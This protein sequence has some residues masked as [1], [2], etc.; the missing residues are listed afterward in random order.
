MHNRT[1]RFDP[2][3][4]MHSQ[5]FEIFHY[6]DSK[7]NSVEMHHHDYYE[8]YF[9][10]GGNVQYRVEGHLYRLEPGDLLLINP[11]ELHQPIMEPS[12]TVYERIVLWINKAYLES[13][14]TAQTSL[15]R[16][17]D[18]GLPTHTNHLR[19]SSTQRADILLHLSEL[20]QECY[21]GEYASQ[22]CSTGIFLQFMTQL[23]RLA[24]GSSAV[25][26]SHEISPLI[27]RVLRYI[28]DHYN[29]DLSLDRL[30]AEF[31][32][33]K[34]HLSHEF[35]KTV[36]TGVYRYIT[37]KRLLIA[38][39]MLSSGVAPGTVYSHCGFGDYANFYRAFKAQYGISPSDCVSS[40]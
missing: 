10:L 9:F 28:A 20:V 40:G 4:V 14:S 30:A 35:S 15:T 37:L 34:Y 3:Q 39:Q 36:G 6:Q 25:R 19:P 33:S 24:L 11:M 12:S 38:K 18:S 29:E 16:C 1:Q 7:P 21:G 13:F 31:Y 22:L 27:T 23:N 8:V 32:V 17:F 26:D 2:R 5:T